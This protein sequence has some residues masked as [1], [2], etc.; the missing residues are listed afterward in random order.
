MEVLPFIACHYIETMFVSK[1]F[2]V[3]QV[4]IQREVVLV[5]LFPAIAAIIVVGR[6]IGRDIRILLTRREVHATVHVCVQVRQEMKLIIQFQ[7]TD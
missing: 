5:F 3:L 4:S 7:I 1:I 2:A 6:R